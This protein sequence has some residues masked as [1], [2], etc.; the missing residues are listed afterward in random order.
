VTD[1]LVERGI[2]RLDQVR[3]PALCVQVKRD[4][5]GDVAIV[6]GEGCS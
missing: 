6:L 2:A 4:E 5:F 1:V 3:T